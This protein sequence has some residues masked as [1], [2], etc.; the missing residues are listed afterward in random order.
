MLA[1]ILRYS[2]IRQSNTRQR[3]NLKISSPIEFTSG[4]MFAEHDVGSHHITVRIVS[5]PPSGGPRCFALFFAS[6]EKKKVVYRRLGRA[7]STRSN[8]ANGLELRRRGAARRAASRRLAPCSFDPGRI[9]RRT[10]AAGEV[11]RRWKFGN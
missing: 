9:H 7:R 2:G 8:F 3:A 4:H 6:S 5:A 11:I 10:P 1:A